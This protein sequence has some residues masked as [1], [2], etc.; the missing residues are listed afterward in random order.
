MSKKKADTIDQ[1]G[2]PPEYVYDPEAAA[3]R[4]QDDG[5]ATGAELPTTP[6]RSAF[7]EKS[8]R[9]RKLL[10]PPAPEPL[11]TGIIDNHTHLDFRDGL[12]SVGVSEAMDAAERVGVIG[13]VQVGCNLAAARF[14][15]Q[16]VEADPRLLGGVAIHPNDAAELVALRGHAE[17]DDQLAEIEALAAHP[18]VRVVGETGLDY[19]RTGSEGVQA[20]KYAFRQHLQMAAR[21]GKPLQIHDRDAHDDVVEILLEAEQAAENQGAKLPSHIVMHCFSGGPELAQ[22]CNEHGWLMSF[23]GPLTFKNNESLRQAAQVARPELVMVETDAPFL[24]P[25]PHRGRPNAPYLVP[26]TLRTLAEVQGVEENEMARI[27]RENTERVYGKL[28]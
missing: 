13:A 4:S 22:I 12:V 18:R 14:T 5:S 11:N 23:A 2:V 24:T 7:E 3:H 21:L 9:A 16:A 27:V 28:S 26:L 10:F 15:V 20:Q 17:L 19:F 25:H 6:A 1:I 8:G